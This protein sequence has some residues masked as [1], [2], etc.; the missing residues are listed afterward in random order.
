[1]S[2]LIENIR[3]AFAN[4]NS[5]RTR[6]FL[7]M[8]GIT[9]GVAAVV[10]LVS[11][12]QGVEKF[13]VGQFSDVGSNLVMVTGKVSTTVANENAVEN[14]AQLFEQL[15]QSDDTA[16]SNP[17]NVPDA[18]H[19]VS[20]LMLSHQVK[21]GDRDSDMLVVGTEPEYVQVINRTFQWGRMFD[22]DELNTG[23]RVAVLG[24]TTVDTFFDGENPIEETIR[25]NGVSFRVVGV[26]EELS[27]GFGEDPNDVVVIPLTAA[28][29]R[30]GSERTVSGEYPVT[31]FIVQARSEDSVD[32]VVDQIALTLREEHDLDIEDDNDFQ[33]FAQTD[34]INSLK[35]I[36][37]LLTVFLG[38]IASISLLVGGI[39]IMNIMMVTVTERTREIGLRKSVGAQNG[40]IL[41]QFL[42]EAVTLAIIG[43]A[44][45]TVIAVT[46]TILA[47]VAIPD[48]DVTV[49][50][51]SILTATIVSIA[52]GAFFGAYPAN[53]AARLNPIDALR[54]E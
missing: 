7:T 23:A 52:I 46:G 18:N 53:R 13:I 6:A 31:S 47:T 30:L 41:S 8:L 26:L 3:I 4:L 22:R 25:V 20:A 43:G 16:L 11:I 51:S 50:M 24:S 5:N 44:V 49:Q 32:A 9:I 48:L 12:G 34:I 19:V 38:V 17:S 28:Q 36:T 42:I 40:D 2:G 29:R 35:A 10:L 14:E 54:Y 39:G 1:M 37:G 15:T 21:Y 45:G 33:I 27:S